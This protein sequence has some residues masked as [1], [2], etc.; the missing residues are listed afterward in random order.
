M[1]KFQIAFLFSILLLFPG[2][3]SNDYYA[4]AT[5]GEPTKIDFSNPEAVCPTGDCVCMTCG[6]VPAPEPYSLFY[7][8]SYAG[9][10]CSFHPCTQKPV[11]WL[12]TQNSVDDFYPLPDPGRAS[13]FLEKG[14]IPVYILY[15]GG[16]SVSSV[17]AVEIAALFNGKGPVVITTEMGFDSSDHL[18]GSAVEE[19]ARRM[20]LACPNCLIALAPRLGDNST[21]FD[22]IAKDLSGSIDLFAFGINSKNSSSCDSS[23]L[24]Y[25]AVS[26]SEQLLYKYKK[27]SVLAYVLFDNGWNDAH[28]CLWDES[29][30]SAAYSDFYTYA[31]AFPSSGIIGVSLYSLS[32]VGP[33]PCEGCG[34]LDSM[35][36]PTQTHAAWFSQCQ[37][38]YSSRAIIPLLFSNAPGTTCAFGPNSYS[39]AGTSF[40]TQ[41]PPAEAPAE[42]APVF[43]KCDACAVL[44]RPSSVG[45]SIRISIPEDYVCKDYPALDAYADIRDIDPAYVRAIVWFES[46]FKRCSVGNSTAP[47]GRNTPIY[48]VTDPDSGC[49]EDPKWGGSNTYTA[50]SGHI[51]DMGLI[52]TFATPEEM[53]GE[54]EFNSDGQSDIDT[55]SECAGDEEFNPFNPVHIAC[56]GTYELAEHLRNA[57]SFVEG[58]EP[59]LGLTQIR[60]TYGEEEYKN[61]KGLIIIM[62]A[63]MQ[64][65]GSGAYGK[66]DVLAEKFNDFSKKDAEFCEE[67][68]D[69]HVCC[70]GSRVANNLCCGNND[71]I[72][73]VTNEDCTR[74]AG[75]SFGG[76]Q[77]PVKNIRVVL[78]EYL[79]VREKCGICDETQWKENLN[80][81]AESNRPSAGG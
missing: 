53:W 66:R 5:S 72:E 49:E 11:K 12:D 68:P 81:W 78:G 14:D 77:T 41:L 52:P 16:R 54:I 10:S 19:Q 20:K 44:K 21:E 27:P 64:F 8:F 51:C 6:T 75:I 70:D 29:T 7:N 57:R 9:K 67:N 2:C 3:V 23:A 18:T 35:G 22:T 58:N 50:P 28:T 39:Y 33:F 38:A 4:R 30:I 26:Y 62:M 65:I 76:V 34:L 40:Y 69:G 73:F 59:E 55:A 80:A 43:Y 79:G 45:K 15:S 36:T 1:N 74:L 31:P 48:S 24:Y 56:E 61:A 25:E 37:Q 32:G 60:S 42:A 71:F 17:R 13:C 46:D 47:C 63:R